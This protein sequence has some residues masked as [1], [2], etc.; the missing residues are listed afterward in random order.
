MARVRRCTPDDRSVASLRRPDDDELARS[1]SWLD[2][3]VRCQGCG[4][5]VRAGE[6]PTHAYIDSAPGCW[7][8]YCS[9][10]DWRSQ[11]TGE[12]S[13]GIVQDLV[14]SFAVQHATNTERRNRQSVAVH[15]MSLCS[16]LERGAT[17]RQRRERIAS[18]VGRG[19]PVLEPGPAD[20]RVTIS[21]VA[22][23]PPAKRPATIERLAL[24]SW[25]AWSVHHDT[26]RGWL[27]R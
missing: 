18:W 2:E 26:V 10:W 20:F 19:Y 15:L 23:T 16:G 5:L 13:I 17:G 4:A 25:A 24:S 3:G 22:A 11:L 14:D 12:G 7:E 27:D 6:G 8:R 9:L 1:C 21:D